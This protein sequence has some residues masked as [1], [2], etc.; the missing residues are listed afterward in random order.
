MKNS[1]IILFTIIFTLF[2]FDRVYAENI[3]Q[4]QINK[5]SPEYFTFI[6]EVPHK[7]DNRLIGSKDLIP[8]KTNAIIDQQSDLLIRFNKKLMKEAIDYDSALQNAKL[9][10]EYKISDGVNLKATKEQELNDIPDSLV[11]ED[12]K[13]KIRAINDKF[14][15]L[16]K[17]K[18]S[19]IGINNL[20]AN[21]IEIT[22][23]AQII[24]KR[25]NPFYIPINDYYMKQDLNKENNENN[26]AE[27][28]RQETF[29]KMSR[30]FGFDYSIEKDEVVDRRILLSDYQIED[31]DR[32]KLIIRNE[33]NAEEF[34][35]TYLIKDIGIKKNI[36]QSLI[37]TRRANIDTE[38]FI[39]VPG[40]SL[41]WNYNPRD[42]K[43]WKHIDPTF[44]LNVSYLNYEPNK[45]FEIGLGITF[46]LFGNSIYFTYGRNLHAEKDNYYIGIGIG[47]IEALGNLSN[48]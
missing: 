36:V 32:I 35:S 10:N 7:G 28:K 34:V 17:T 33:S 47:F 27:N 43:F 15:N 1:F 48:R 16:E 5:T 45:E 40:V 6:I 18:L 41:I 39:P 3:A 22:I 9:I 38:T 13:N 21:I 11:G 37:F 14:K 29:V 42:S 8:V 44:G 25:G 30:K 4:N 12:R 46:G 26:D 23:E 31:G 20:E 24:P 19:Q 2:I